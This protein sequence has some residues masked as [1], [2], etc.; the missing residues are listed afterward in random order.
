MLKCPTVPLQLTSSVKPFMGGPPLRASSSKQSQQGSGCKGQEATKEWDRRGMREQRTGKAEW[1]KNMMRKRRKNTVSERSYANLNICI[2]FFL[3]A[4][5]HWSCEG[6]SAF[7][8]KL[9][10][11]KCPTSSK[12]TIGSSFHP[13]W[14]ISPS[15]YLL[16]TMFLRSMHL[17]VELEAGGQKWGGKDWGPAQPP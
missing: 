14:F 9:R 7:Q 2:P 16:F 1:R 12:R 8:T 10:S 11:L 17:T 13:H 6:H 15:M 4:W 3:S 5:L